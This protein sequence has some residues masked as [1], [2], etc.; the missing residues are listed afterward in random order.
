VNNA[1]PLITI[2]TSVYNGA[3]YIAETIDSVLKCAS[4]IDYEYLIVDDGSNDLTPQILESYGD[5]I[6]VISRENRGESA[7]VTE[8]LKLARGAYLLVVSADDPLLTHKLFEEVFDW[9]EEDNNLVAV[10]PDWQMIDSNGHV[11]QKVLVPDFSDELLIGRCRTLPGPGVIFRRE[12]AVEIGGRDP[13]WV[14][15]GDY[16]FWL[17]LIRIGEIRHRDGVLAQWRHH[18]NS[19]SVNKRGL[20]MAKERIEVI[21]EFLANAEID[22]RLRRKALG[23]AYYTAARLSF[24]SRDVPGKQFLFKSFYL[25]RGW[26]EEAEFR[27]VAFILLDPISRLL[28]S[29]WLHLNKFKI[30]NL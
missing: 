27:V 12:S 8:A 24:F 1:G 25:R 17:R 6:R 3:E 23:N 19:T 20:S 18:S 13:K 5:K 9:F 22:S 2:I 16:D 14:Y 28:L 4:L 10:Y 7:S 30:R 15:V 26:V 21:E 11:I 29:P